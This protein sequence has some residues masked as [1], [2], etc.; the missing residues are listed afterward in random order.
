MGGRKGRG[1][2]RSNGV[3]EERRGEEEGEDEERRAGGR[4]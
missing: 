3:R 4:E 1:G 2:E